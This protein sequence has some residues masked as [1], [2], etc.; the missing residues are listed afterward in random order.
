MKRPM[1]AKKQTKATVRKYD[2]TSRAERSQKSQKL[3]IE[4]LV[5]LLVEQKGGDVTFAQIAKRAKISER[6]IFRFFKDKEA[7]GEE[8]D[9]YLM[10]YLQASTEQ[11]DNLDVPGFAKNAFSIFDH[12]EGLMMAYLYSN[13]GQE[14]R[15]LFRRRL[16]AAVIAKIV[17]SKN[18]PRTLEN[19]K[20][21]ALIAT[22]I[23]A[24]IWADIRADF[25]YTGQQMGETVAWAI[26][27]LIDSI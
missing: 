16:H 18:F 9:R 8:M 2:N 15:R 22:L 1:P 3:I 13:F 7:L 26:R 14:T 21:L 4:C 10:S 19:E 17:Q 12:H 5:E 20:K 25:G 6:S 23:N 24:K 11:L 27:S